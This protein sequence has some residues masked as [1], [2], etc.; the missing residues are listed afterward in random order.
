MRSESRPQ[1]GLIST[2]SKAESEKIQP[3]LESGSR[4][5]RTKGGATASNIELPAPITSK[6]TN[7]NRNWRLRPIGALGSA[8]DG[9]GR[10]GGVSGIEEAASLTPKRLRS[11]SL[12]K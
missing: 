1:P 3:T 4:N 6:Q 7:S 11:A 2:Q 8:R 9:S 12:T 5:S 10:G